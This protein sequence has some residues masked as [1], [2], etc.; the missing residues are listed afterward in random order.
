MTLGGILRAM[1]AYSLDLRQRILR[2]FMQISP[3]TG[4]CRAKPHQVRAYPEFKDKDIPD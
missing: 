2:G 3:L 4:V 1:R